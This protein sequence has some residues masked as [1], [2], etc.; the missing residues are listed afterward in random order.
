MIASLL[1]HLSY[2][3]FR[4]A[5]DRPLEAQARRLRRILEQAQDSGI[6]R[7]HD[8]AELAGIT[9]PAVM[10]REFQRR[11][12]IRAYHE[13]RADLDAVY[14]GDWQRLCPSAPIYFAMTAGSTGQLSTCRSPRSSGARSGRRR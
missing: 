6:G 12:P 13:M 7:R 14:A 4:H 5:C 1:F 11:I 3:R 10:I 8:F 9:D 2:R